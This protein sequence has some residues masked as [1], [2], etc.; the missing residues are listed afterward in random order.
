MFTSSAGQQAISLLVNIVLARILVP[1]DFGAV[2]LVLAMIEILYT[3]AEMGTSVALVQRQDVTDSLKDSAFCLTL[4]VT[5]TFVLLVWFSA[6]GLASF[7]QIPVLAGLVKVSAFAYLF[8]GLFSLY[9]CLLLKEL[10]YRE[11]SLIEFVGVVLYGT[12]SIGMACRGYG[13]YSIMWGHVV[14]SGLLVVLGWVRTRY[15]PGSPGRLSE[16][17]GLLSFGV[18]VSIGRILGNASGKVDAFIIGKLLDAATLGSYYLAQ[19]VM[20]ILPGTYTRII[21]QVMLPIYSQWQTEPERMEDAYWK[22]LSASA[23]LLLPPILMI[24]TFADPVLPW[25]L[26]PQW[27]QVV[28]LARIMAVFGCAQALGGGILG[29]VVY[30]LGRPQILTIANIFR[31]IALPVCVIAGSHWGVYGVTVG[32][33]AYGVIGRIFNQ[34]LMKRFLGY[35]LRRYLHEISPACLLSIL[36]TLAAFALRALLAPQSPGGDLVFLTGGLVLWCGVYLVLVWVCL[37][38]QSRYALSLVRGLVSRKDPCK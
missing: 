13:P 15:L 22:T 25:V 38:E 26:G 35:S 29:T 28:I 21:D 4:V 19:K 23:L 6:G 12:I 11:I 3:F 37:P 14:S 32:V 9:R 31:I 33:S 30:A 24:F 18:W 27:D 36:A 17:W 16:M 1:E 10:R 8:R 34:W 20:M 5:V 7:F 2:A